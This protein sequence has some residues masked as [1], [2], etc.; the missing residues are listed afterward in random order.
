MRSCLKLSRV[1]DSLRS[2]G[3]LFHRVGAATLNDLAVNVLHFVCGITSKLW[4]MV[5]LRSI[6]VTMFVLKKVL[7]IPRSLSM[8]ELICKYTDF[9]GYALSDR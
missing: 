3:R 4:S 5:D 1:S 8:K 9:K 2:L 6:A 7:E